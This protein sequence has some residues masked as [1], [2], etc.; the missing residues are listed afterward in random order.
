M[1][2]LALYVRGRVPVAPRQKRKQGVCQERFTRDHEQAS[3]PSGMVLR[4]LSTSRLSLL[5]LDVA[6]EKALAVS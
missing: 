3:Y 2:I 1:V 5:S 6:P 4:S